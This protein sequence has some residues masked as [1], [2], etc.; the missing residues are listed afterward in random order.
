[1][2]CKEP[3]PI[4]PIQGAVDVSF[5]ELLSRSDAPNKKLVRVSGYFFDAFENT[6]LRDSACQEQAWVWFDPD[7]KRHT[8]PEVMNRFKALAKSEKEF[9]VVF[10]GIAE[11]PRPQNKSSSPGYG[12]MSLFHF[13][14]TVQAIESVE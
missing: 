8:K 13:Q 2:A 4:A 3:Q 9:K 12:H 14:I 5:C 1:M 7:F 10:V 6:H 11:G